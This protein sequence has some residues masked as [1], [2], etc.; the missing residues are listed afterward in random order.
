MGAY[1]HITPALKSRLGYRDV[2]GCYLGPLGKVNHRTI[3]SSAGE[4]F[5]CDIDHFDAE[6]DIYPYPSERFGA[7]LCCELIEHLYEDPMHLM[8]EVNRILRPGGHLVLS[9]PNVCSLRAIAASL[10]NYHPGLFHQYVKPDAEGK[11]DPRHAREYAPRDV[12]TLFESAG[13]EVVRL[14][15]GPYL[16]RKS[17]EYQWVRHLLARYEL[18]QDHREDSI[19]CVGRKTGPVRERYPAALYAGGAG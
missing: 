13:F 1:L 15:T 16:E 8:E 11:R 12:Q 6:H 18:P 17:L 3:T 14:E 9:T 2:R 4:T 19:F 10:L 7:V 5:T